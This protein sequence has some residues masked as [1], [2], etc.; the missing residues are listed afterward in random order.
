MGIEENRGENLLW[1]A[2]KSNRMSSGMEV[3][4]SRSVASLQ[5][6]LW[7]SHF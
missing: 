1:N 2:A 6:N 5:L 4:P 7:A 3:A